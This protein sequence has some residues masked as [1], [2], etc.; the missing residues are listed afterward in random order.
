MARKILTDPGT[1]ATNNAFKNGTN[2]T[3]VRNAAAAASITDDNKLTLNAKSGSNFFVR[4]GIVVYD[5][6]GTFGVSNIKVQRAYLL[7]SDTIVAAG[8]TNGDKIRVGWLHNPNTLG[9]IHVNDYNQARA[10]A[11]NF[12][13]EQAVANG[14]DNAV[15]KLNNATLLRKLE[16]AI[17]NHSYLHLM[18]RSQLDYANTTPTAANG[19]KVWFDGI[20]DTFN[21]DLK[22]VIVYKKQGSRTNAGRPRSSSSGMS[23]TH[24][25]AG[26][27]SGFGGF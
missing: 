27:K 25:S 2:Y 17:N 12:T 14:A 10:L 26:T 1:S 7:L 8:Q 5:F 22:L 15:I 6:T 18:I 19:S 4:R 23:E 16:K 9:S 20:G 11:A 24:I 3:T 21:D 13:S